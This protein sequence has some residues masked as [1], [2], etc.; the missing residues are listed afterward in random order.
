[1]VPWLAQVMTVTRRVL[2]ATDTNLI[3]TGY[4]GPNQPLISRRV[5]AELGMRFVNVD[6]L[7]EAPAGMPAAEMRARFGASRL[8]TLETEVVQNAMLNRAAVIRIS[9]AALLNS[10]G[11]A[12]LAETGPVVCLVASLDAV[13]QRLHLA[14]GARYHNPDERALALGHLKREWAVRALP[15][16]YEVDTTYLTEAEI[17]ARVVAFWGDVIL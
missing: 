14:L 5:A 16:V 4:T 11:F 13:L 6:L 15:G 9:G 3:M 12:G 1:M 17:V 10:G 8:K 2:P 7:V